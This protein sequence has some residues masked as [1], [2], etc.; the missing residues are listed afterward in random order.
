M[1]FNFSQTV[2]GSENEEDIRRDIQN[3]L[4]SHGEHNFTGRSIA[5][6]LQG[7]SSP[8][9]P[10]TDWA[11]NRSFW[12]RHLNADFHYLCQ[13]AAQEVLKHE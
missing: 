13:I 1:T 10:A 3:L 11:R 12:R 4:F 8:C 6:I 9:F 7:I 5:K 2:T